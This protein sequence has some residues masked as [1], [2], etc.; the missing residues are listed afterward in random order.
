LAMIDDPL[1]D[2][3]SDTRQCLK[4]GGI[5]GVDIDRPDSRYRVGRPLLG[6]ALDAGE[7]L[8]C[9]CARDDDLVGI[10]QRGSHPES[11]RVS[12]RRDPS[13]GG[14]RI[15]HP[16]ATWQSVQAR[17]V[18]LAAD[19]DVQQMRVSRRPDFENDSLAARRTPDKRECQQDEPGQQAKTDGTRVGMCC[20]CGQSGAHRRLLVA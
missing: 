17:R 15:R 2:A 5:S 6:A 8:G 14:Y 20:D 7:S 3:W 12:R 19:V 10:P 11:A 4:L 13:G 9:P 16:A 18:D 1:S